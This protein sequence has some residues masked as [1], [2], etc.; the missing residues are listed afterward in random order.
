MDLGPP[1]YTTKEYESSLYQLSQIGKFLGGD[2][3]TYWA[4]DQLSKPP[5]SILEVGCGGGLFSLKLAARY[6][7]A[8]IS[9]ID[10]SKEAVAFANERLNESK[11]KPSNVHFFVPSNLSLK[12]LEKTYDVI[13]TTLVCHH[14]TNEE[15]VQFIS[16]ACSIVKNEIIINDL[17]RHPIAAFGFF[18]LSPFF[19]RMVRHDGQISIRRAFKKK[20]WQEIMIAAGIEKKRFQISWHWP[21]R[22]IVRIKNDCA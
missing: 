19:N 2:T 7:K 4:F 16:D 18:L 17:H 13:T 21:F 1:H 14:L 12:S 8:Q 22:W 9:G 15:L 6:P 10:I 3:A 5:L 20:D 11:L